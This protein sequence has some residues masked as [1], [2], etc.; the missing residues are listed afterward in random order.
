MKI[1]IAHNSYQHSGGE[2]AVVDAEIALLSGRGHDVHVYRRHNDELKD[3]SRAAAAVSAVWS[4]RAAD[5]MAALCERLTPDVIHVHNTFPLISPSVLWM[6]H[7]RRIPVV[8]TLHNFRLLCPQA[9]FLREGRVCEDCLGHVPWRGVARK[10]YRDSALQS[11]VAAGML[12]THRMIGTWNARIAA[13]IALSRFCRD[14]FI[15]G[16]L[17]AARLHVKPNF[18]A[19]TRVPDWDGRDGALFVGRLSPEKGLHVLAAAVKR[20]G[21]NPVRIVGG[22]PLVEE[23]RA[24]FGTALLGPQPRER[25]LDLLHGARYLVAP[26]TSYETFGLALVEAYACGTP[27]IA[28]GHGAFAELVEDGVTGLLFRPGDEEDLAAKIAWAEAHPERMREMGRAAY[29]L[30]TAQFTP[31]RNAD[32]LEAIYRHAMQT[33]KEERRVA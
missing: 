13:Y 6:A 10:C 15:A 33:M 32:M 23:A 27:V 22:G 20:L 18:V 21:A 2:D 14:K 12:A 16:G 8:Q 17:P 19:S 9:M 29:R 25:V 31:A 3:M 4:Q 30:Y 11:A 7:R 28:S 26:S 1:L 5:E 24:A